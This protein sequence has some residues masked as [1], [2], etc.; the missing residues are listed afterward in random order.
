MPAR[1][2]RLRRATLLGS[3]SMNLPAGHAVVVRRT[4]VYSGA[5]MTAHLRNIIAY[6]SRL[7][8]WVLD[9]H[10]SPL[11]NHYGT[12]FACRAHAASTAR[13]IRTR[14]ARVRC[15][16]HLPLF[17][18]GAHT[19]TTGHCGLTRMPRHGHIYRLR[20]FLWQTVVLPPAAPLPDSLT[21]HAFCC[22]RVTTGRR[23]ERASL[24]DIPCRKPRACRYL[25]VACAFW[26][27]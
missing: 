26:R 17:S 8:F 22:T 21:S 16:H 11:P 14:T 20:S 1:F 5:W 24:L 9:T 6:H 27:L 7:R 15:R 23:R 12:P 13:P 3:V 19:R 4:F 18:P 25:P 2:E 10:A